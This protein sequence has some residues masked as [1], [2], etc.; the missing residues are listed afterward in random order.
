MFHPDPEQ[1]FA[2][3]YARP[4]V[5]QHQLCFA[6][7]LNIYHQT[8]PNFSCPLKIMSSIRPSRRADQLYLYYNSDRERISLKNRLPFDPLAGVEEALHTGY[9]IVLKR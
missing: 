9:L 7:P 2:M 3:D 5:S 4:L 8:V 1:L 6:R